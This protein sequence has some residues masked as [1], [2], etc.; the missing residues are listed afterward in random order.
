MPAGVIVFFLATIAAY[1]AFQWVTLSSA[2]KPSEVKAAHVENEVS[3]YLVFVRH[4]A[5][6]MEANPAA[7]GTFYW[8]TIA[9]AQDLPASLSSINMPSTWRIVADGTSYVLCADMRYP[10]TPS[11]LGR[12]LAGRTEKVNPV[13]GKWVVGDPADTATLTTE[14]AKCS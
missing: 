2:A 4:A 10:E 8:S 11:R 12:V 9:S 3:L 6:Y 14:A 1:G 13:S 5:E 7:S